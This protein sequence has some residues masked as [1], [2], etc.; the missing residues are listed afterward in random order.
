[1]DDELLP[2]EEEQQRPEPSKTRF[3][4]TARNLSRLPDRAGRAYDAGIQKARERFPDATKVSDSVLRREHGLDID[5][6]SDALNNPNAKEGAKDLGNFAKELPRKSLEASKSNAKNSAALSKS[7]MKNKKWLLGGAA[8]L[9]III[10]IVAFFMWMMLFKN[11]HIKNLY[12]TYRWAQFNR[13]LNKTL[14]AQLEY[15]KT[16]PQAKAVGTPDTTVSASDPVTKISANTNSDFSPDNFDPNDTTK[17]QEA[18]TKLTNYEQS[19]AGSTEKVLTDADANRTLKPIEA[20]GNTPEEQARS[21]RE[22]ANKNIE[23]DINRNRDLGKNPP[24]A[25]KEGVDEAKKQKEAGKNATDAANAAADKV[26]GSWQSAF[27][28]VSTVVFGTTMYCIFR[29]IYETAIDQLNTI[30]LNGS[31]AVAQQVNKTADAAKQGASDAATQGALA[32]RFDNDQGSFTESCGAKN[33]A[34]ENTEDCEEIDPKFTINGIA[35][36]VGDAAGA[37]LNTIDA[38]L[39]PPIPGVDV[40]CSV[41]MNQGFQAVATIAELAAIGTSGGGWAAVAGGA[42][43]SAVAFISTAGGKALIASTIAKYSGSIYENLSPQELGNLADMG[44]FAMASAACMG[45]YCPQASD[46]QVAQLDR[47]YRTERIVQNSKR[48]TFAK[49]FD[50]QSPDSV[51]VRAA[52]NSPSTPTAAMARVKTF[53]A[54]ITNPLKLH[55]S[56]GKQAL[57]LSKSNTA[58]AADSNSAATYGMSNRVAVPPTLLPESRNYKDVVEWGDNNPERV[59]QLEAIFGICKSQKYSESFKKDASGVCNWNESTEGATLEEKRLFF[60]Y[61]YVKS[62]AFSNALL[63]NKQETIAGRPSSS[64]PA[65]PT[66]AQKGVDTANIP[67]PTGTI[68]QGTKKIFNG[69]NIRLCDVGGGTVVNVSAADA[70]YRMRLKAAEQGITLAGGG[71]RDY[72][73][74]VELRKKHCGTSY[75]QIYETPARNCRPPTAIPGNSLHEEGLAVDY[76]NSRTRGTAVFQWL[77]ANA[78]AYGIKNLP[79]EPWHWSVTGG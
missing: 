17:L 22:Q 63:R 16:N 71:Y 36:E 3:R 35:G 60:E 26:N 79:S 75:A 27:S 13:G 2:P 58:Y 14:K 34:L 30:S 28:K 4:D 56:F 33:A 46:E 76:N 7:L 62:V 52:L 44:N 20:T 43:T 55:A 15:A 32:E 12:V 31:I 57:A 1:V 67:C 40:A 70:Y 73:R 49:L 25:L 50:T 74:Q 8:G 45:S 23:E 5:K 24:D 42:K 10:P 29:D 59:A 66:T 78:A 77:A 47:E 69:A 6:L 38:I 65:G 61:M 64:S 53:A 18:S 21:L 11:V 68:N 54:T 19:V 72:D 9:G 37:G 41:F 48:S 39:D 51:L